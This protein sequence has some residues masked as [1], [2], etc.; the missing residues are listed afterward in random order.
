[1]PLDNTNNLKPLPGDLQSRIE[2]ALN[3]VTLAEA[4]YG[5]L[6]KLCNLET[7]KIGALTE[8]K[9]S[10]EAS[11]LS[12][13]TNMEAMRN[14]E[15]VSKDVLNDLDS[16]KALANNELM[17]TISKLERAE[18]ELKSTILE[19]ENHDVLMAAADKATTERLKKLNESEASHASKVERLKEA[20]K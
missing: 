14:D 2:N 12:L 10:L 8:E 5:R 6:S 13:K 19:K 20:L 16:K 11:I 1:M 4:E 3:N 15:K 7:Q 17:D 18:S 9:K